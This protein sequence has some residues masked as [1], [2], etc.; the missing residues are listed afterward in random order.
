MQVQR[1]QSS[2][3]IL[4]LLLGTASWAQDQGRIFHWSGKLSPDQLV[5]IKNIN[6]DIDAQTDA[7]DQVEVTAEKSG[8][9][10]DKIRIAVVPGS[11]GVTI[12]AIYP[13]ASSDCGPGE[14][15]Y[16]SG[17]HGNNGKVHFTV[18]MSK[19]LR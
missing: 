17:A 8:S 18:R 1:Y 15:N 7:T 9:N 11:E 3:L 10:A 2:A 13:G 5:T 12:C 14:G 6:G 4:I 19:N 16:S